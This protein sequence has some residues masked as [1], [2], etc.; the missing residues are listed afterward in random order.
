MLPYR[1]RF[2]FGFVD[3][4]PINASLFQFLILEKFLI[5]IQFFLKKILW[6]GNIL[7]NPTFTVSTLIHYLLLGE[8]ECVREGKCL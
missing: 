7:F 1:K 5:E 2:A 3:D 4:R 8:R 6:W